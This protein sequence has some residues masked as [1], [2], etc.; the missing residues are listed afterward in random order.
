MGFPGTV[1][2]RHHTYGPAKS[3]CRILGD[4]GFGV[5]TYAGRG[6]RQEVHLGAIQ[7][8][9]RFATSNSRNISNIHRRIPMTHVQSCFLKRTKSKN[10]PT[11]LH[12]GLRASI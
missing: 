4:R 6:F 8:D 5:D 10:A 7:G 1:I 2:G 9:V 12:L 11:Q 3:E